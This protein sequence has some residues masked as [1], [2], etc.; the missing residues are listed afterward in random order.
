MSHYIYL[1]RHAQQRDAEHGVV[2]APLDDFGKRQAHKVG[3]R[4][5]QVPFTAKYTSPLD[6][7]LETARIIDGYTQ[8]PDAEESTLLFDC[9]PSGPTEETPAFYER[10]FTGIPNEDIDAGI[11]QM[12]DAFDAFLT[13]TRGDEHTLIVTHNFV[14][15]AFIAKALD[16]PSWRWLGLN[17]LNASISVLRIRS[18]KPAELLVLNDV[19]HLAPEERTGATLAQLPF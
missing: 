9:I 10:F 17:T 16:C 15:G 7:A 3:R 14:I 5:A 12:H 19:A 11:A 13:R 8:G 1:V 4:L 18:T 2:D 6:R